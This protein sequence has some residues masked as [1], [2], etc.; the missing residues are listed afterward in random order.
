MWLKVTPWLADFYHN[1][2][3]AYPGYTSFHDLTDNWLLVSELAGCRQRGL[4][5]SDCYP[6]AVRG[7]YDAE[8]RRLMFNASRTVLAPAV[9][10]TVLPHVFWLSENELQ[11]Y[12]LDIANLTGLWPWSLHCPNPVRKAAG[13]VQQ[14]L[15][16][17][18]PWWTGSRDKRGKLE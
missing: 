4:S 15:D 10:P 7:Q 3:T 5:H 16:M 18:D 14:A 12:K 8:I 2:T 11:S 13:C 9:W 6:I 17:V 1:I